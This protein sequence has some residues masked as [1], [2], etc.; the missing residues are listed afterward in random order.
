MKGLHLVL[1]LSLVLFAAG[2][3]CAAGYNSGGFEPATFSTG[4]LAGQ[5]G[6]TG[7]G[8]GGGAAPVVVTAPDP[9]LGQQAVRL[10]VGDVQ[11][12]TSSMDHAINP[13]A[14]S[15]GAIV[16]VSYDIF[17]Y[18]PD[19]GKFAQNMWWWWWDAGEPTYGLQWDVAGAAGQTLP[20]GWNPGA[21]AAPTV[22]GAWAN[23]TMVWDFS[24]M[25]AYSWYNGALV[26]NGIPITNVTQLTGWTINLGHEAASGTGGAVV[27]I[28][29]FRIDVVP[30]PGSLLAL[31]GGLV[32]FGGFVLRRRS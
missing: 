8:G 5:D 4:A 9:V 18:A 25:K 30:E 7:A 6:W 11:G 24:Q 22:F 32:G 26:D 27:W 14:A 21:G 12:D 23:L 15:S 1:A 3:T 31:A 17:R 19:S 20:H 29:N 16:T 10:A 13:V 28:D 2:A